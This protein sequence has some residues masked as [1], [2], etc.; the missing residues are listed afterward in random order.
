MKRKKVA[1]TDT[2]ADTIEEEE[3]PEPLETSTET[4]PYEDEDAEKY[5]IACGAVVPNPE[6]DEKTKTVDGVNEDQAQRRSSRGRI[7][8]TKSS[9]D[10]LGG[11]LVMVPVGP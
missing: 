6:P 11:N 7:A 1:T 8:K 4:I 10:H 5:V 9:H 3:L 2:I